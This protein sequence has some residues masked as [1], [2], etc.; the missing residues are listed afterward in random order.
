MISFISTFLQHYI[1]CFLGALARYLW[2]LIR[3]K[4]NR[5]IKVGKFKDYRN[6]SE[7]PDVE[8]I[9]S[10]VGFMIFGLLLAVLIRIARINGWQ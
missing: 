10:I 6:Y 2:D 7:H 8:I 3:T 4:I 9:D 5:N 1:F